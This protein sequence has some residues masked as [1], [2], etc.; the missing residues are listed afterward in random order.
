MGLGPGARRV[1]FDGNWGPLLGYTAQELAATDSAT[2]HDLWNRFMQPDDLVRTQEEIQRHCQGEA[3]S[4]ESEARMR[5]KDGHWISI[6]MRGTV[7]ERDQNGLA[8][9]ISGTSIDISALKHATRQ[10]EQSEALLKTI[11][12]LLPQRVFWKDRDGRFL[13]VNRNFRWTPASAKSSARPTRTFRG[14]ARGP[15]PPARRTITSWKAWQP[16]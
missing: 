16:G 12:D 10:A 11:I 8:L 4:F 7:N 6:L 14:P 15:T 13:G 1:A 5:H 3:P 9:R 2:A